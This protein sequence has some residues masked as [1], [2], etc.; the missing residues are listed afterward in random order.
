MLTFKK[1]RVKVYLKNSFKE[2]NAINSP[3]IITPIIQVP[4][5]TDD[6]ID[7]PVPDKFNKL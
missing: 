3:N 7:P 2:E 1:N 4:M 6:F 5:L